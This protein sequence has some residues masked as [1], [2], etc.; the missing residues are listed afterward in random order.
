MKKKLH[1]H[2]YIPSRG[3]A[4]SCT[5]PLALVEDGIDFTLVVE[6]QEYN[7]YLSEFPSTSIVVL[8][9]NDQGIVYARNAIK[10]LSRARGDTYHWQFDDDLKYFRLRIEAE[11]KNI[12][13]KPSEAIGRVEEYVQ[14]YTNIGIA[15][16][17]H[18]RFAYTYDGRPGV[19]INCQ[20]CS[21]LLIRNDN[22]IRW[23][24]GV[25]DDT[26]YSVQI[27]A[28]GLCTAV[29][30]RI[31]YDCPPTLTEDGGMSDFSGSAANKRAEGLR[32]MWPGCFALR[33]DK[34]GAFRVKPSQI[35]RKFPQRP[36]KGKDSE[37]LFDV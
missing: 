12:I 36:L 2:I 4:K 7:D 26:D 17:R 20:C 16:P 32:D 33:T 23:R 19:S 25:I 3:R 27:L 21:F 5:T 22:N 15:S 30:N 29:F 37:Y 1:C 31:V 8:D 9:K 6:P 11:K 24:A 13:V 34:N 28:S 14:Q 10:E 35:W 18:I